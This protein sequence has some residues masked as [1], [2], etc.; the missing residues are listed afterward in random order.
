M[1][2]DDKGWMILNVLFFPW[3]SFGEVCLSVI[4]QTKN[5]ERENCQSLGFRQLIVIRDHQSVVSH[6]QSSYLRCYQSP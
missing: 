5:A 2:G 4:S 1:S 3:P 6:I